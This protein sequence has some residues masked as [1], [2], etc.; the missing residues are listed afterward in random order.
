MR[1]AI[2][3]TL[4]SLFFASPALFAQQA[5]DFGDYVVH[6]NAINAN[7]IPPDVAKAYNIQRSSSRA[8]LNITVLK[9]ALNNP[10]APVH[11]KVTAA[12]KNL[13]GQRRD[14]DIREIE[15]QGAIYYLGQFRV[16]DMEHFDFDVSVTPEG[17]EEP[18]QVKFRQQFY[19]E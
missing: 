1:K 2:I 7:Q 15:D 5:Q 19:T 6:Y 8:V 4:L 12:A 13:T 11:A 17:A 16:R 18:L 14:I 9:K 3:V 10:A